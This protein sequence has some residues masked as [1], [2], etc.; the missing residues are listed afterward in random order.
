[1]VESFGRS[2]NAPSPNVMVTW[3]RRNCPCPTNQAEVA[4]TDSDAVQSSCA[5]GAVSEGLLID[6][7]AERFEKPVFRFRVF[8]HGLFHSCLEVLEGRMPADAAHYLEP[9]RY[10]HRR[11][12][13]T[14]NE[15]AEPGGTQHEGTH[16]GSPC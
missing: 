4:N 7:L 2:I 8:A 5:L 1:M 15:M 16:R 9:I 14:L 10:H 11:E 13:A 3:L 12:T 6:P